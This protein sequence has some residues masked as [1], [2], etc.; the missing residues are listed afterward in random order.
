MTP[1][2]GMWG[3]SVIAPGTQYSDEEHRVDSGFN[4][5]APRYFEAMRIP[6]VAGREFTRADEASAPPVAIVNEAFA[7]HVWPGEEAVGKILQ[8][9]N[10]DVSVIGIA[11]NA[12]YYEVGEEP[13]RQVYLPYLQNYGSRLTFFLVTRGDPL[14]LARV[15]EEQ[16][17]A[18]DPNIALSNVRTLDD[19]IDSELASY[20]VMAILV[21]LFGGLALFLAS[22]G[23]YG[24]QS[25]LVAGRTREIGI[26]MAL[27]AEERQVAGA[28]VAR[29]L[30]G[31]CLAGVGPTGP[32]DVVRYQRAGS[33]DL[34]ER[35]A[36]AAC[37]GDSRH[38]PAGTPS[39]PRRSDRG[40]AGGVMRR[41]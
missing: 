31:S 21:S 24:V 4:R 16:F 30:A 18:Q 39:Q 25:Y 10:R 27:G 35:A 38:L 41:G 8:R 6:I 13:E 11:A 36:G 29:S 28:V 37:R 17:R 40:P 34:R 33:A 20:R 12:N 26:R 15:V 7:E 3:S 14:A 5:V 32:R 22:I 23:L 9:R 2:R 1:F 19:V